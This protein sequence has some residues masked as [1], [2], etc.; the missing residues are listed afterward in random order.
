MANQSYRVTG[1][2]RLQPDQTAGLQARM[3][4]LPNM[5]AMRERKK[6]AAADKEF[7]EAQLAQNKEQ[8]DD[9][10]EFQ[11]D[12]DRT[13]FGLEMVKTGVNLET[14]LA[15]KKN[16]GEIGQEFKTS[17]G[18]PEVPANTAPVAPNGPPG[19]NAT[20]TGGG[21]Q[22]GGNAAGS[23]FKNLQPGSMITGGLAGYGLG[24]MFKDES[25]EKK[26]LYGAG[27]GLLTGLLSGGVSGGLS[28]GIGGLFGGW[29]S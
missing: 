25:P 16:F 10:Q 12:Q 6:Q 9:S 27:A 5:M 11:K 21:A 4:A 28:G 20:F 14:G 23:F 22:G 7:R 17:F 19:A 13:A 26:M 3:Q 29:A 18:A 15:S 8:F 1:N 24:T 2:K